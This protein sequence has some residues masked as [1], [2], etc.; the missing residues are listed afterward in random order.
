MP[1]LPESAT[2]PKSELHSEKEQGSACTPTANNK[3]PLD[4][5]AREESQRATWE[6]TSNP[7]ATP[8]KKSKEDPDLSKPLG[9]PTRSWIFQGRKRNSSTRAP[10]RQESPQALLQTPQG[11]KRGLLH[12]EV[13]QSYFTSLGISA[14]A[15][16]EPFRVRIW[17]VLTRERTTKR[18]C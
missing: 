2:C 13:H 6:A 18:K 11:R 17:L 14:P 15:N 16:K 5:L 4:L 9:E 1:D 10:T 3:A 7:F 8:G 12:S